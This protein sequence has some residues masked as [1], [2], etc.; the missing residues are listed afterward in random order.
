MPTVLVVALVVLGCV[1]F[2]SVIEGLFHR[3][4][5]HTPQ[6]KLLRGLLIPSYISHSVEHHPA[7]RGEDYHRDAPETEQPISLGPMMWPATMLVT[8][9]ITIAVW[10]TLG[11]AA[12]IAVPA[13][14]TLYYIAYEFLHWHMHFTRPDG[15]PRW[16]HSWPPS[17]QLFQWFDKRHYI[18]HMDDSRNYNV[19]LPFYDIFTGHYSLSEESVP[20]GIRRRK[21]KAMAKAAKIRAER[22][23]RAIVEMAQPEERQPVAKN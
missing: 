9:P 13:T 22:A 5:L 12:G 20:W 19:V 16:Y 11:P 10:L 14:F 7:Y 21:A 6:K 3:Y 23:A 8:S 4:I 17:R 15:E 2:A 18:H 1:V